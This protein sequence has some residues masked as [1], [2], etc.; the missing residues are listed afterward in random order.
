LEVSPPSQAQRVQLVRASTNAL[1]LSW[2]SIPNAQYYVL[3]IQKLPVQPIAEKIKEEVKEPVTTPQKFIYQPSTAASGDKKPMLVLQ[4]AKKPSFQLASATSFPTVRSP[5]VIKVNQ[6][7]KVMQKTVTSAATSIQMNRPIMTGNVIKLMPG[8]ILSGNKII[9]K[10]ATTQA[11]QQ[12]IVGSNVIRP[13]ITTQSTIRPQQ[14]KIMTQGGVL[15]QKPITIGG[16]TVTLQLAAGQK[17]VTL[18]G[19]PQ[20][21][22]AA[23]TSQKIIMMPSGSIVTSTASTVVQKAPTQP[24]P[25]KIEQLDGAVDD[26]PLDDDIEN[27]ISTVKIEKQ[28]AD[29]VKVTNEKIEE[30][31]AAAILS[32]ISEQNLSSHSVNTVIPL[33]DEKALRNSLNQ[34]LLASPIIGNSSNDFNGDSSLDALAAAALEASSKNSINLATSLNDSNGGSISLKQSDD[35]DRWMLVGVFKTLTHNVANYVDYQ[36]EEQPEKLTSENLPDLSLLEKISL[37]QGRAYRFR[38]AGVNACGV[39]K[40]SEVRRV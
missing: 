12:L 1:E 3:E 36:W 31:E 27:Q 18:V 6:P 25:P 28:S 32:T 38:I 11:S 35:N 29:E 10:P 8:T 19:N 37:E 13:N 21:V 5:N 20:Q 14:I 16:K 4:Q 7:I 2:T 26:P 30:N 39:G 22:R 33:H 9:M 34:N 24:T 15:Q 23:G 40:F 17:K